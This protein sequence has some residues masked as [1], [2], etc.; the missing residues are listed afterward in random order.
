MFKPTLSSFC[1]TQ[2]IPNLQRELP[3]KNYS[4]L[5]AKV[6]IDPGK[7]KNT[8]KMNSLTA[9]NQSKNFIKSFRIFIFL[10]IYFSL[11]SLFKQTDNYITVTYKGTGTVTIINSTYIP[12]L[13]NIQIDP[14][15]TIAAGSIYQEQTLTSDSTTIIF[16]WNGPLSSCSYMLKGLDKIISVDLTHFD[17]SSV[18][19][20]NSF[21]EGCTSLSTVDLRNKE[22][23]NV[24]NMNS[25]FR[26]CI[27]LLS[28]NLA[29]FNAVK[30]Q[31]LSF[32]FYE[33]ANITSIDLSSF[34][35][36]DL[37]YLACIF[38]GCKL[39]TNLKFGDNFKTS[40]VKDMSKMFANCNSLASLDLSKF[41]TISVVKMDEM[42]TQCVSL[43]SLDLSSFRTPSLKSMYAMFYNNDKLTSV[44]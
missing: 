32:L 13:S 3:Q 8:R 18:T 10:I 6:Q 43:T 2:A 17:F 11:F 20:M 39:L 36:P 40:K 25:M 35:T 41:D 12:S 42:F 31:D 4:T 33:C 7:S 23:P 9:L 37:I 30:V 14:G 16:N 5:R 1:Q 21:F 27:D 19:E 38:S 29:G 26:D 28:V 34:D 44:D 24:L 22:A 15:S